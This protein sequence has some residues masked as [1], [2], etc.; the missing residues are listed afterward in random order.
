[1]VGAGY[2]AVEL[3]GVLAG[4]GVD[5]TLFSRHPHVLR[6]FDDMIQEAVLEALAHTGVHHQVGDISTITRDEME[7]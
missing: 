1:M 2:I 6:T 7:F 4:L 3:S 5:T